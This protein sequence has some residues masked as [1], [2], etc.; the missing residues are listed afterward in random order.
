MEEEIKTE[1][2]IKV[3]E[4]DKK[5]ETAKEIEEKTNKNKVIFDIKKYIIPIILLV[6][7]LV[8]II[9]PS[10][11]IDII[12]KFEYS[13]IKKISKLATIEAYYHNVATKEQD[14][15]TLG[16]IMFNHGYKKYWV[17]YEG[18]V[19]FGVDAKKIKIDGPNSDG[20]VK[21][22]MPEGEIIG[23]PNIIKEKVQKPITD[24]GF[25]TSISTK[26]KTEAVSL[27][28]EKMEECAKNDVEL[29]ELSREKAKKLIEKFI[30]ETGKNIGK[31]YK[32]EFID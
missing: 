25:L 14:A 24:T 1:E 10:K 11:K 23:K 4:E 19:T 26:E 8:V 12:K 20:V 29:L 27:A 18:K 22:S 28:Q 6:I 13:K 16:K 3:A 30:A 15:S 9:I 32:V 17:E 5:L 7:T 31:E 21:V 2:E